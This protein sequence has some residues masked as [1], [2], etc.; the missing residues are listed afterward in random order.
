MNNDVFDKETI[1][2]VERIFISLE[3]EYIEELMRIPE[4]QQYLMKYFAYSNENLLGLFSRMQQQMDNGDIKEED[5]GTV[6]MSMIA[7]ILAMSE[8]VK[9]IVLAKQRSVE[10]EELSHGR[11][12]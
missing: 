12:H 1:L 10:K 9:R 11:S 8:K 7:C 4:F 3:K 6:E 2:E 5:E